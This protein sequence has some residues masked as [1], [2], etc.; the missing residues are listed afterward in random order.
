MDECKHL[1]GGCEKYCTN[2][3]GSFKCSC[4]PGFEAVNKICE[5]TLAYFLLSLVYQSKTTSMNFK[6]VL[7]I[8]FNRIKCKTHIK[9]KIQDFIVN[10]TELLFVLCNCLQFRAENGSR[11]TN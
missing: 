4:D 9:S 7:S 8:F 11:A 1:N 3:V 10:E 6:K 2:T 5:G